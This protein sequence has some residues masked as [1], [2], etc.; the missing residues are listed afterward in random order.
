MNGRKREHL[1]DV[2]GAGCF[3]AN[4]HDY[5]IGNDDNKDDNDNNYD[6][7]A[8]VSD[9]NGVGEG[10]A[11]VTGGNDDVGD[12]YEYGVGGHGGPTYRRL[13]HEVPAAA[14]PGITR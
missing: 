12:K 9:Y 1:T 6:D 2:E 13:G 8:A 3:A 4:N 5:D 11:E 7:G 14:V 10:G